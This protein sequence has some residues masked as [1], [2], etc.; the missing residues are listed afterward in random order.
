MNLAIV[1]AAGMGLGA[2]EWI[3]IVLVLAVLSSAM[4]TRTIQLGRG[5]RRALLG[6]GFALVMM[7]ALDLWLRVSL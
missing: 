3:A 6:V 1:L 5:E 2:P 4:T 7:V